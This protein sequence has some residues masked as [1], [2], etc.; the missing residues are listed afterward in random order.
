MSYKRQLKRDHS[1]EHFPDPISC[2]EK[3]NHLYLEKDVYLLTIRS[4]ILSPA[5]NWGR[6]AIT[7]EYF[8]RALIVAQNGEDIGVRRG[9]E[10]WMTMQNLTDPGNLKNKMLR[11]LLLSGSMV[12]KNVLVK[13]V[14]FR[15]TIWWTQ[16]YT[17]SGN[18]HIDHITVTE[19][20]IYDPD[21]CDIVDC[22]DFIVENCD[23]NA[24]D[25]TVLKGYTREGCQR[26]I[27]RNNKVRTL[28]DGIKNGNRFIRRIP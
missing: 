11:T 12:Y 22:D 14:T 2:A 19:K 6:S 20:S 8:H 5:N 26:G 24:N 3:Q 17:R 28:C 10:Y 25:D 7:G 9:R 15:R 16:A 27:I 23:I 18:V 21:G 1:S 13:D 4:N